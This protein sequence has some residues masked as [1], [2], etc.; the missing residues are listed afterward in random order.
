VGE[1]T[2]QIE[3]EIRERRSDLGRNLTELEDKAR[4][5]ADWRTY[6]R[7]HPKVFLGAA[8][9][10]GVA[11]ALTT[12]PKARKATPA[13]E[14]DDAEAMPERDS[15]HDVYRFNGAQPPQRHRTARS[16]VSSTKSRTRGTTSP[17]ACWPSRQPKRFRSSAIWSPAS[18][19]TWSIRISR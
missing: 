11:L 18:A 17:T 12:V 16:P 7:D 3:Q 4:Q 13:F 6:F 10:A 1:D 8:I 5:L 19:I 2:N 15:T 14:S 9:G